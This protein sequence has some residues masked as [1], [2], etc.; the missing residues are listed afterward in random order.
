MSKPERSY[1]QWCPIA[2]GL[3]LI[4][5][6]WVLLVLRELAIGER[7]FTDL[8]VALAGIAPNLL[9]ERLRALRDAGLVDTVDL[10]PPAAR[11]VYRLTDDGR[12][13]L[14]VLRAVAQFG[15]RHLVGEPSNA[16]FG[17]RRLIHALL[18]PWWTPGVDVRARVDIGDGRPLDVV[19][20][21][22]RVEVIEPDGPPD[23]TLTTTPST[24]AA[25]RRGDHAARLV[26]T[27]SASAK[28]AFLA[29]FDLPAAVRP[30]RGTGTSAGARSPRSSPARRPAALRAHRPA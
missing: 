19:L 11:T 13:T 16:E 6:R 9:S 30:R 4:G 27:G 20:A 17:A 22:D 26:L 28:R 10:P 1:H 12:Q 29:V 24:L 25:V 14:P 7:R 2:V 18:L 3:D 5:D 8:R 21:G 23:V 15:A